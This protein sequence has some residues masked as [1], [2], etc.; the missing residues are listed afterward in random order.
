MNVFVCV[1][2]TQQ[3][4]LQT[5]A[6]THVHARAHRN[7]LMPVL[8]LSLSLENRLIGLVV[9]V[10]ASGAEDPVFDSCLCRGYFSESCGYPARRLAT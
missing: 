3:R 1:L 4:R 6:R 2:H 9:K 7:T 10:S 8:S 5:H